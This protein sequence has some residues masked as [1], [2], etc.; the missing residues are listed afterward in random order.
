MELIMSLPLE[1]YYTYADYCTWDDSERWELVD[2]IPY[3]M[4][5]APSPV[6][7][8]ILM[9]LS[10]QIANFLEDKPC[11]VFTAPFDVRLNAE[12]D[13]D[14]D[15]MQPDILVVCDTDKIDDKGL[16]GAPDMIIEILSP[17]TSRRDRTVKLN[18][19]QNAGVRE[20]WIVDPIDKTIAV[21]ILDNKKYYITSYTETDTISVYILNGCEIS[22]TKVFKGL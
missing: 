14:Y 17:S 11:K 12:G 8:E 20:Y 5:P 4:S 15:V 16:N 7:Q 3:A 9:E 2:G 18:K 22:L 13:N 21:H 6:H 1:K 19:Y 10:R